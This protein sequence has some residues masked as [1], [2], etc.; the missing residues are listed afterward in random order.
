MAFAALEKTPR[1]TCISDWLRKLILRSVQAFTT[2]SFH[3]PI[4]FFLTVTAMD[5]V[6][7]EYG[8]RTLQEFYSEL[9]EQI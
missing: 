5:M 3:G 6:A 7:P 8:R 2:Q 4:E 9:S 1:I